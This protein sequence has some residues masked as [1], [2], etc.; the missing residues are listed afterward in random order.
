MVSLQ[1][2]ALDM[3]SPHKSFHKAVALYCL[4][5][6]HGVPTLLGMLAIQQNSRLRHLKDLKKSFLKET[7]GRA[8]PCALTEWLTVES[9]KARIYV[10]DLF[11]G[12]YGF[13][14]KVRSNFVGTQFVILDSGLSQ[15]VTKLGESSV[16]NAFF[17]CFPLVSIQ[18]IFKCVWYATKSREWINL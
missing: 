6:Y 10:Q 1:E 14:G 17:A 9:M 4:W 11:K 8:L 7:H 5:K 2:W 12:T 18:S 13:C 16:L 15:G 3:P